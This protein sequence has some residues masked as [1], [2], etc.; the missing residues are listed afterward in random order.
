MECPNKNKFCYVCGL[1]APP[2]HLRCIN[3]SVVIR[4]EEYFVVSYVPNLWYVPEVI[5][6]YCYRCLNGY[7]SGSDVHKMKYVRPTIWLRR[8]EHSSQHCYFCLTESYGFRYNTR[9]KIVYPN[10][11]SVIRAQI[12]CTQ[13]PTAPSEENI[14][15]QEIEVESLSIREP[16]PSEFLPTSE[17]GSR[18]PH[19]VTQADFNDL[20]RDAKMSKESTEVVGSRLKQWNLVDDDFKITSA[21][22]RGNTEPFCEH[23]VFH[24]DFGKQFCYCNDIDALFEEIGHPHV[25]QEWRL[26]IDSSVTSLKVVLL[27]IGNKYPSV[28]IAHATC[29]AETYENMK[30]ILDAINYNKHTWMICC[31]LKVVSLL[32]GVKKGFSRHQCFLCVWEGRRKDLHYTNFEWEP[33]TDAQLGQFSIDNVPLVESSK[34]I[35]PPLHIKLGL[36]RNFIRALDTDSAAFKHIKTIFPKLSEAKIGAGKC[37]MPLF[38]LFSF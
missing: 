15:C 2:K 31:D 20:V 35:L 18:V 4:F 17:F 34:V 32:T 28:P 1:F 12:R 13:Y 19:F 33:R 8:T 30:I 11:E 7:K 21:R 14:A 5:C 16:S 24:E 25:A 3:T 27:H 10:L 26:F 22:K 29:M 36:I 23:F 38:S 9:E 37:L 6:D